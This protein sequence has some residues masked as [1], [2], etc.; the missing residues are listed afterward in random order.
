LLKNI[1]KR[2]YAPLKR[3]GDAAPGFYMVER[4]TRTARFES[5]STAT[6]LRRREPT[7]R[8]ER[9]DLTPDNYD[10]PPVAKAG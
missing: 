2:L 7:P 10:A 6:H 9:L 1:T 4:Y 5:D 3:E 8:I